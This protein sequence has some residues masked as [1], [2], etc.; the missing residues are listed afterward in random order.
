MKAKQ[1]A[2]ILKNVRIIEMIGD[3]ENEFFDISIDSRKAIKKS[4]FVAIKGH[5]ID[6]HE[7]IDNAIEKGVNVILC[8]TLPSEIQDKVCYLKIDNTRKASGLI[9]HA[10]LDYPAQ[11]M[12]IIGVTGTNGKTSVCTL[13]FQLFRSFGYSIP[14]R[15]FL[16][17]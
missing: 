3:S 8:E 6:G 16:K 15:C 17:L 12:K 10:L 11:D 14:L 2:Y 7:F 5:N 13:L 9:A 1:L 4:A